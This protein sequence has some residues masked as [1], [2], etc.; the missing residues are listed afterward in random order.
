MIAAAVIVT[1]IAVAV[2]IKIGWQPDLNVTR[3]QQQII[4]QGV[5]NGQDGT[6]AGSIWKGRAQG[7]TASRF[8][9]L[10]P[11]SSWSCPD[12]LSL[13]TTRCCVVTLQTVT[14]Q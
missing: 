10:L 6:A 8:L 14:W 1:V 13:L 12:G 9:E 4:L 7:G 11:F 3:R 2:L 5:G